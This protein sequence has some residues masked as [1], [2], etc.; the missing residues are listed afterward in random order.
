M[1]EEIINRLDRIEH[2][3]LLASKS[4][5]NIDEVALLTGFSKSHLYKLTYAKRIPY[6]KN[7]K[8]LFFNKSEIEDWMLKVRYDTIDES[9]QKASKYMLMNC[10]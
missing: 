9:M 3:A 1:N 2:Y 5:L 10:D 6:Y 7:G 4:V 8:Y